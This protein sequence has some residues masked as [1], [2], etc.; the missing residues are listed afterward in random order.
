MTRSQSPF[1]PGVSALRATEA[2]PKIQDSRAPNG[3]LEAMKE[4]KCEGVGTGWILNQNP[5]NFRRG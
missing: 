2:V 1:V 3:F 5:R 4:G